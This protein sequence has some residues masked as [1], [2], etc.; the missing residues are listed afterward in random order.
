MKIPPRKIGL[1][2]LSGFL[3][4]LF[5]SIGAFAQ[6]SDES[7]AFGPI[8]VGYFENKPSCFSDASGQPSGIFVEILD[9]IAAR[10][11]WHLQYVPGTWEQSLHRLEQGGVDILL[12][13]VV[14]DDRSEHFTF[15]AS[16]IVVNWATVYV[17]PSSRIQSLLD[18]EG[19]RIATLTSGVHTD[20]PNGILSIDRRFHFGA[21]YVFQDEYSG[22]FRAVE[23]GEADAGVVN[24]LVGRELENHY[25]VERTGIVFAPNESRFALPSDGPRTPYLVD[26][27]NLR[28]DELSGGTH[29]PLQQILSKYVS[30]PVHTVEVLPR[31][32]AWTI[33]VAGGGAIA[34][35]FI[36]LGLRWQVRQRTRERN[37]ALLSAHLEIS[38]L[39]VVEFDPQLRVIRWSAEAE[40]IFGWTSDEATGKTI[41]DLHLTDEDAASFAEKLCDGLPDRKPELPVPEHR[42]FHKDG[43]AIHCEWYSSAVYDS[44]GQLVS[45]LSYVLDVTRRTQVIHALEESEETLRRAQETAKIG[46]WRYDPETK[47]PVWSAEMFRIFHLDPE[48]G[49]P[50]YDEHRKFI[51]PDDWEV[52]DAAVSAAVLEGVDY[53]LE[54]RVTFPEGGIGHVNAICKSVVNDDGIVTELIG[55]TQ[56]I[57]ERKRM[58]EALLKQH[59]EFHAIFNS[60][61]DALVFADDQRRIVMTNP[62]FTSIF[63]Y[64][65][66]EVAGRTTQFFYANPAEYFE[67]GKLRYHATADSNIPLYEV[68]YRRKDGTTFPSETLGVPVRDARGHTIGYLGVIRD[69]SE[70]KAAEH[71]RRRLE[72][73][74]RQSQKL[75]AVGTLAGG[76]AHD[77]NNMLGVILGFADIAMLDVPPKSR[78]SR[79]LERIIEA[80]ERARDLVQQILAFSRQ[81]QSE[82]AFIRPEPI[83][84]EAL[85]MLRSSI[86][87]TIEIQHDL[88]NACGTIKADPTQLHQ[89]LMNLC[90][91]AYHAM[92][93]TGGVLRVELK[94]ADTLPTELQ[95]D[96]V[97]SQ[98]DY[99]ELVVRDTGHG[100]AAEDLPRVFD[101]FF[102]TKD[103]KKGTGM[104]LAITYG[105]VMNH[106]GFITV[107]SQPGHGAVFRVWLVRSEQPETPP[108]SESRS[109]P[110]GRE[111]ILF[112]DDETLVAEMGHSILTTL[113]Y[114]VTTRSSSVEA[115]QLF[116]DNPDGFDLVIT[117]QTM[118]KM[119]GFELAQRILELRPGLPI[120]LCTGYSSQVDEETALAQGVTRFALKPLGRDELAHAVRHALDGTR[121]SSE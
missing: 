27:I 94:P 25:A 29:S 26:R 91:N 64:D 2:V 72:E 13:V 96:P 16:P 28:L 42:S 14:T 48:R 88:S 51:H 60:I 19:A 102:S 55:T 104:G 117:D 87:S 67:Q 56:D 116:Q 81:S 70:R 43:T 86:P 69:V 41:A 92:E 31:W 12:S 57:S 3:V 99:V 50:A 100:I 107:E 6:Q 113:G 75:E 115:L 22:I 32:A 30:D 54:L 112:V 82:Q 110:H 106:G 36:V 108:P 61:T 24:R 63:G 101:P 118:P 49:I 44:D 39:G 47:Q 37:M 73:N 66:E 23:S 1:T 35:F 111:R 62:A 7:T 90:T 18:L 40:R 59:A 98:N 105:I 9:E 34:L 120:I 83:I 71:E 53:N 76:I 11:G 79:G 119:T 95:S 38:P 46:S 80:A 84:K 5:L 109:A 68:E 10:E 121:N 78:S 52:F 65:H 103:K 15:T 20:G 93:D 58:E 97:R 17:Q 89:I 77:F 8:R 74:W 33:G 21:S 4:L 45:I 114:Q 85:R